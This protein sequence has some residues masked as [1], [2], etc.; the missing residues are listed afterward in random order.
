MLSLELEIIQ[1]EE[2]WLQLDFD[3]RISRDIIRRSM[4]KKSKKKAASKPA[5]LHLQELVTADNST[6]E[7]EDLGFGKT[8]QQVRI[9]SLWQGFELSMY[10]VTSNEI[11]SETKNMS[12]N[13]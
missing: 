2:K 3:I 8:M 5:E 11:L 7:V 13:H 10:I 1:T 6:D 12:R 4:G 9:F